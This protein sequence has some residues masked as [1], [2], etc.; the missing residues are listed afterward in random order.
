LTAA[1][2]AVVRTE[3]ES[4]GGTAK[5]RYGRRIKVGSVE[6][7]QYNVSAVADAPVPYRP[8]ERMSDAR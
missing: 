5:G 6:T 2:V 4:R 3:Q 7:A 8:K 1:G